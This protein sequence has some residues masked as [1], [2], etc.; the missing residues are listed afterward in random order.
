MQKLSHHHLDVFFPRYEGTWE[1]KGEFLKRAPSRAIIEFIKALRSGIVLNDKKYLAQKIFVLGASFGGG[2]AL[3]IASQNIADKICA[4]SPVISFKRIA[5]IETLENCLRTAF[6]R[7]YRFNPKNWRKLLEDG[8]WS[9]DNNKIKN[10]SN[11]L[12]IAGEADDQ[13]KKA[14]VLE[15]GK[16]NKIKISV[17]SLGHITLSKITEPILEEILGFFS[18]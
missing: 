1:S 4:I 2:V 16:K 13:I 5:G 18:K 6:P 14:D 11:V 15:F 7:D 3:D 12:I 17:Y 9:L 8:L 10:P